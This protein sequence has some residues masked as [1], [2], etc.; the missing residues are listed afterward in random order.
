MRSFFFFLS[1]SPVD[2]SASKSNELL[3]RPDFYVNKFGKHATLQKTVRT[4]L[5]KYTQG[6]LN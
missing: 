6:T 5:V 2:I 3:P 4:N 1:E